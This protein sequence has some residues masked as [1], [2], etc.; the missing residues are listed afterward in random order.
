MMLTVVDPTAPPPPTRAGGAV[1]TTLAT[2]GPGVPPRSVPRKSAV[3]LL[4]RVRLAPVRLAAP[5]TPGVTV[6]VAPPVSVTAPTLTG[7]GRVGLPVT[8]SAPARLTSTD[9]P[10]RFAG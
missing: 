1:K 2:P 7:V 6:T 9:V 5:S 10:T 4:V 3:E 8:A